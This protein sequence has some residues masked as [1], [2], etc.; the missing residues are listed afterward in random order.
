MYFTQAHDA[1]AGWK[2]KKRGLVVSPWICWRG[3]RRD[4]ASGGRRGA[5]KQRESRKETVCKVFRQS[6]WRS[7]RVFRK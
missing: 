1:G 2:Q 7:G 5:E 4:Q 3:V 6:S